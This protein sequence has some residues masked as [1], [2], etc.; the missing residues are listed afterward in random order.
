MEYRFIPLE[1]LAYKY[2]ISENGEVYKVDLKT[3]KIRKQFHKKD[4]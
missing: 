1:N 2:I 3:K 4:T